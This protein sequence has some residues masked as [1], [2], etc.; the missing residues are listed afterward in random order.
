VRRTATAAAVTFV[1]CSPG[2]A[3]AGPYRIA[4]VIQP[5]YTFCLSGSACTTAGRTSFQAEYKPIIV[6]KYDLRIRFSR[7]YERAAEEPDIDDIIVA[8]GERFQNASDALDFRFRVFDNDGY[9]RQEPKF[10][11][12][13][14][15]AENGSDAHHTFF[16]S[17]AVFFGARIRRGT[18]SPAHRFRLSLKISKDAYEPADVASQ[19]FLQAS[20]YATFPL[21][22]SG[23]WRA[24]AGCTAQQQLAEAGGFSWYSTRY[25]ASLTHDFSASIRAYARVETSRS[26]NLIA[27]MKITF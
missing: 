17:D 6:K 27:G 16:A 1:L 13:Y 7:S 26:T 22:S 9:E 3:Q 2:A 21:E 11:Y 19:T 5:S 14:Q 24:E 10:G 4:I 18:E 25:S 15:Y 12:A 23:M 8:P 20:A